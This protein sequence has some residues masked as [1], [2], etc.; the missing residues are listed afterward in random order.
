MNKVIVTVTYLLLFS[1]GLFSSLV[2]STPYGSEPLSGDTELLIVGKN[3]AYQ[4]IQ[5]A[6][7]DS[8][9]AL[10]TVI[11][12]EDGIYNERIFITR[13]KIA[14]V[15][16]SAKNTII[17]TSVLRSTWRE[18]HPSDWG[19]A[20]VNIN[21]SD[22]TL[23]NLS[24]INEYGLVTGD[25]EHQFAVRGF[26]L[27]DRIITHNCNVI[28]GGADTLSLWNKHGQYYHSHCYFEGHV[29]FVCPRGT[30]LIENS[31][32][33]NQKQAATIWHD[34]ELAPNYKLVV[35]DSKFDG[36]PGFWL[37]RHHYD[38]QFYLLNST[39]SKN[40]A[41]KPIFRKRY[42]NKNK[43]RANLYGQRYFFENNT[44]DNDYPWLESNFRTSDVLTEEHPTLAS[45][46]FNNKWQPKQSL[47]SLSDY[48]KQ[49]L[50]SHEF[51]KFKVN[52]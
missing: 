29:D 50:K 45:W 17:K 21:A 40:M 30:A 20:T 23:V 18:T 25:H 34:G 24:I 10:Q 19:A 1:I 35:S 8:S 44:S 7:D 27:S 47:E 46:V 9:K 48:L 3:Q 28:A 49:H 22:V 16:Q 4:S 31:T 32:F 15:G 51:D 14:L 52:Q 37:A 5:S 41:D 39:F 2:A 42:N 38:A 12:I 43:E 36:I 33:Y 26:E 13:N 11:F 6:I